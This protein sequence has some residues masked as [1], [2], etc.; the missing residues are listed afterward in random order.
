MFDTYIEFAN[1]IKTNNNKVIIYVSYSNG[2][3]TPEM[4]AEYAKKLPSGVF[5]G[6]WTID[7]DTFKAYKPYVSYITSNKISEFNIL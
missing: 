4:F 6:A 5:L 1:R 3:N 2:T 7:D